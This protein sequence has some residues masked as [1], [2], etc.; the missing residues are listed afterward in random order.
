MVAV[1][2]QGITC[3]GNSWHGLHEWFQ[4][5]NVQRG[6]GRTQGVP[7]YSLALTS[8]RSDAR[9]QE[10]L[11]VFCIALSTLH[12]VRERSD[13]SNAG[14]VRVRPMHPESSKFHVSKLP[15]Q[16]FVCGGHCICAIV[17]FSKQAI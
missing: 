7:H 12:S 4:R 9:W 2:P 3:V 14:R 8:H 15:A 17:G 1:G 5:M 10:T 6:D 13:F 16:R 11:L